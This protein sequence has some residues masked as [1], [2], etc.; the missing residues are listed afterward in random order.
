MA[1]RARAQAHVKA[2]AYRK[3]HAKPHMNATANGTAYGEVEES[4]WKI[5]CRAWESPLNRYWQKLMVRYG[6]SSRRHFRSH[7][8]GDCVKS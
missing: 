7:C 5:R 6:N 3:A 1:D 2:P 8:L 4:L